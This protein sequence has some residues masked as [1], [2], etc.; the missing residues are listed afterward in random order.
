MLGFATIL[1]HME[2][3]VKES[4]EVGYAQTDAQ[5]HRSS[6]H[7]LLTRHL[8]TSGAKKGSDLSLIDCLGQKLNSK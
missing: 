5:N 6:I 2:V 4:I 7:H 8:S 3:T 1:V